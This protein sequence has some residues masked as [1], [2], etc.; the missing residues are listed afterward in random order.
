MALARESGIPCVE[1][2]PV[3]SGPVDAPADYY[4]QT[5]RRNLRLLEGT[6]GK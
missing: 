1:V 4:E 3:A 2:D 6:L 5:M